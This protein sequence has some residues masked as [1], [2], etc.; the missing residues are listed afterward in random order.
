MSISKQ[1]VRQAAQPHPPVALQSDEELV[2]QSLNGNDFAFQILIERYSSVVT[3]YLYGK[4]PYGH[5]LEDLLQDVFIAAHSNLGTLRNKSRF[6]P[7]LLKIARHRLY[8]TAR[9]RRRVET[10]FV[11]VQSDRPDGAPP[12]HALRSPD[13]GPDER[14]SAKELEEVVHTALGELSDKYRTVVYLRLFEHLPNAT[15]A[16]RL[17]LRPGAAR[18]RLHRGL[19]QLRQRLRKYG[20]L[21]E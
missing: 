13:P 10:E 5:E 19:A 14:L 12:T 8:D 20:Y 2:Q 6:A 11:K 21:D 1:H 16:A 3:G 18:V 17:D 4:T 7:W 9:Q 15:I